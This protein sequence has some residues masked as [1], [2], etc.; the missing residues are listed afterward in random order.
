MLAL[1]GFF[2]AGAAVAND[3]LPAG[4]GRLLA[5]TVVVLAV[6]ATGVGSV[7]EGT[8]TSSFFRFDWSILFFHK[9]KRYY[10]GIRWKKNLK[11]V[12]VTLVGIKWFCGVWT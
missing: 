4:A 5:S 3:P 11:L 1:F 8:F 7:M 10:S 12:V 9:R 6:A 2:A